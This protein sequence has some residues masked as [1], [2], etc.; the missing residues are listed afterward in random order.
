LLNIFAQ[1][2]CSVVV[3]ANYII[4]LRHVVA[5]SLLQAHIVVGFIVFFIVSAAEFGIFR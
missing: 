2:V 4:I 1:I 5:Q 3:L